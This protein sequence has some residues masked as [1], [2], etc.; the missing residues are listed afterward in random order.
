MILSTLLVLGPSPWTYGANPSKH[1]EHLK[2]ASV[3]SFNDAKI[4]ATCDGPQPAASLGLSKPTLV[5]HIDGADAI[6]F[7]TS[8]KFSACIIFDPKNV[9]AIKPTSLVRSSAA[10]DELQ[11]FGTLKKVSG[12]DRYA[13]DTWFL[14][15]ASP[16][17]STLRAMTRGT[18]QSSNIA[19]GFAFIHVRETDE[20]QGKFVYGIAAGLSAGGEL[21]GS[22]RLR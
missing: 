18:S 7:A 12:R 1:V 20:M 8:T 3:I 10:V 4:I 2:R 16:R 21:V 11:S 17:V 19:D 14:V 9:A 13:S 22:T 15:R 6:V 5:S